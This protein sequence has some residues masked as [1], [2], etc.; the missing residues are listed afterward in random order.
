MSE[1]PYE[2]EEETPKSRILGALPIL[3]AMLR[4]AKGVG[5]PLGGV[6]AK[7]G[8]DSNRGQLIGSFNLQELLDD[9]AAIA[10]YTGDAKE[11]DSDL[12]VEKILSLIR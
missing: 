5:E 8:P 10:G 3:R 6:W 4:E 2:L 11:E 12:A 1:K 7:L 9:V